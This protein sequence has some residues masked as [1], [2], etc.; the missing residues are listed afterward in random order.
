MG[1]ER[2][3]LGSGKI[4]EPIMR[5]E[6]TEKQAAS[7]ILPQRAAAFLFVPLS[8]CHFNLFITAKVTFNPTL[9]SI[10]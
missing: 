9:L 6:E 3:L 7:K 5:A 10:F 1:T 2:D 4:A 8:H